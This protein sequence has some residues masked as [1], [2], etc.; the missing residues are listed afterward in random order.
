MDTHP[1]PR[2]SLVLVATS[3][4]AVAIATF[5]SGLRAQDTIPALSPAP[6]QAALLRRMAEAVDGNRTGQSQYLVV[7]IYTPYD[8]LGSFS[9]VDSARAFSRL[10]ARTRIAGPYYAPP[11][12]GQPSP[13]YLLA[14][15]YHDGHL[16]R[17]ICTGD[18][19]RA[20]GMPLSQVKEVIITVVAFDSTLTTTTHYDPDHADAFF[21]TQSA[22][23]KFVLPYYQWVYGAEYAAYLRERSLRLFG[24]PTGR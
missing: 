16:T 23:D 17:Y 22:I 7:T 2:A 10:H 4:V 9:T 11:D 12:P 18:S 3:A 14:G 19:T 15:C 8:V 6:L 13:K 21:F 20:N 1:K 24:G 5:T